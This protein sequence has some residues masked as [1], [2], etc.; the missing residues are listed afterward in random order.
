MFCWLA[1]TLQMLLS[2]SDLQYI[3]GTGHLKKPGFKCSFAQ[4]HNHNRGCRQLLSS[5]ISL[6]KDSQGSSTWKVKRL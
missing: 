2:K 1:V 3:A 6:S 5:H 4:R